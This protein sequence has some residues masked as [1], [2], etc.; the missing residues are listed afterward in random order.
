[1]RFGIEAVEVELQV[2]VGK[3]HKVGAKAG[4]EAEAGLGLKVLGLASGKATGEVSGEKGWSNA[5]TQT[6]R[7]KLKPERVSGDEVSIR[8]AKPG[9][10]R[11][12]K[13][14]R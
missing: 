1:M 6:V 4:V 7:L 9:T 3:E 14:L 8:Q 12:I 13:I 2:V 11:E 10:D 5:L